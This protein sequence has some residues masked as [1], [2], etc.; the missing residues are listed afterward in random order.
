MLQKGNYENVIIFDL[1]HFGHFFMLDAYVMSVIFHQ[2]KGFFAVNR[3][4]RSCSRDRALFAKDFQSINTTFVSPCKVACFV[5]FN[6]DRS[7][8]NM[9]NTPCRNFSNLFLKRQ[10]Q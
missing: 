1:E 7:D 4:G 8:F 9:P 2:S 3:F 5:T 6:L 10:Y